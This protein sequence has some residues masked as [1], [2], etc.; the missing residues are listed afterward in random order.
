MIRAQAA[1]TVDFA[2]ADPRDR[3]WWRRLP[4]LL[5][6]LE[7]EADA[8]LLARGLELRAALLSLPGLEPAS[9]EQLH[10]QWRESYQALVSVL[11]PWQPAAPAV[12]VEALVA[13]YKEV[14]GDPSDPAVL[15]GIARGIEL[16]KQARAAAQRKSAE[17]EAALRKI[18][19]ARAARSRP[20]K[21]TPGLRSRPQPRGQ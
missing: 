5:D 20:Q 11:K 15:A 7:D 16:D 21:P 18:Q 1:G 17:A 2:A 6:Q 3:L 14:F 19:E 10:G 13:R 8:A 9:R 12:P 4:Y